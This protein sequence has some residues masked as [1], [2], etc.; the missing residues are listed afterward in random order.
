MYPYIVSGAQEGGGHQN[1]GHNKRISLSPYVNDFK[2]T[3]HI[4][5]QLRYHL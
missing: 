3:Q 1:Y 5:Y 4:E 2:Q